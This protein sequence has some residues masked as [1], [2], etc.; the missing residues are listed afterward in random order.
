V[1]RY[2][3][4]QV[5]GFQYKFGGNGLSGYAIGSLDIGQYLVGG[6]VN[7][8]IGALG[9]RLG[10]CS[11]INKILTVS[12]DGTSYNIIF[13]KNYNGTDELTAPNYSN[14]QIIAEITTVIG[15]VASVDEYCVGRDYY[16]QFNGVLNMKNADSSEV[17]AGMGIIFTG[18][19]T[20]R[21]ASNLD[22][23][24]DGIVLD[25]GRVDDECRVITSGEINSKASGERFST[26]DSENWMSFGESLGISTTIPGKFEKAANPKILK[27]TRDNVLKVL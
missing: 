9:K 7:K 14:T 27:C 17:L 5:Y 4:N 3:R 2:N 23:K 25:D 8:Y 11:I 21:K 19:K 18:L 12:V 15:S 1:N 22:G 16:P 20:F 10:D 6:S 24:I 13:N 26:C